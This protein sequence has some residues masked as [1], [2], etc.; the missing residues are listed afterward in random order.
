MFK[1]EI[2]D[3]NTMRIETGNK[4]FD[5][6]CKWLSPGAV[7][8]QGHVAL[9]VRPKSATVN[10]GIEFPPGF[11]HQRDVK[12]FRDLERDYVG[13]LGQMSEDVLVHEFFHYRGE[14]KIVHGWVIV[15]KAEKVV[16]RWNP[17]GRSKAQMVLDYAAMCVAKEV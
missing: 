16:A 14:T 10:A 5:A 15:N 1:P 8:S 17:S 2:I 13:L 3:G 9:W 12:Q 4:A 11:L 6:Y 7:I